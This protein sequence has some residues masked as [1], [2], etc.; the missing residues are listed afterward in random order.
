MF[1]LTNVVRCR[2]LLGDSTVVVQGF[3]GFDPTVLTSSTADGAEI[4]HLR[5][6]LPGRAAS[7]YDTRAIHS[8][9]MEPGDGTAPR[10]MSDE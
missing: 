5:R 7:A 10:V 9:T 8:K 1:Q 3:H 6:N 2:E 4:E